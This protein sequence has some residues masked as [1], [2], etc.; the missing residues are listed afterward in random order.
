[1]FNLIAPSSM[2]TTESETVVKLI[3]IH[4]FIHFV[5]FHRMSTNEL[6][7]FSELFIIQLKI[8]QY[9]FQYFEN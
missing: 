4:S 9:Y 1:M 3:F 2:S 6:F 5:I 8:L 7:H